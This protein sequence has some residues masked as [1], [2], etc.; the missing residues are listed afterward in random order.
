VLDNVYRDEWESLGQED[1]QHGGKSSRLVRGEKLGATVYEL[2]PGTKG[3]NYHFHHGSEEYL[4]VL[5]GTPTLRTPDGERKLEQG[6]VVVFPV[7]PAGAHQLSNDTDENVRYVFLSN[8]VTPEV[9]EYP[10]LGLVA[11]MALTESQK[12]ER[13]WMMRSLDDT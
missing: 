3:G 12:G 11:T 5:D 6:A 8:R 4:I 1:W 7:G 9:V 10:D 13:L 2:E